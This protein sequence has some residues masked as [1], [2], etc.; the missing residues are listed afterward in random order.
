M[1]RVVPGRAA[2]V[3]ISNIDEGALLAR[4]SRFWSSILYFCSLDFG[5]A[6]PP[7]TLPSPS[8]GCGWY[9]YGQLILCFLMHSIG[10]QSIGWHLKW[11]FINAKKERE[12]EKERKA[13]LRLLPEYTGNSIDATDFLRVHMWDNENREQPYHGS[14]KAASI[15]GWNDVPR[16][17]RGWSHSYIWLLSAPCQRWGVNDM[18]SQ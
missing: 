11:H 2:T 7:E 5:F 4:H 1:R 6:N 13:Q 12:R 18:V 3:E 16:S 17:I 15:V 14:N 8:D 10:A 9:I